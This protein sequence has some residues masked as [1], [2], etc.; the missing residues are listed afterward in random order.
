MMTS[1]WYR[2]CVFLHILSA[3]IYLG[4][5]LFIVMVLAPLLRSED[6]RP[7][8]TRVLHATGQKFKR[9]SWACFGLLIL[10]GL[11]NAIARYGYPGQSW[12]EWAGVIAGNNFL[13]HK[14]Y[15]LT[16]I[17]GLSY[18]HDFH[19]GPAAVRAMR[20]AADAPETLRLRRRA[21]W[22]GRLNLLFA[23]FILWW[24][25]RLVRG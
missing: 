16:L 22:I 9:I 24:A 2:P 4:G 17:L 19:L 25:L 10:T 23:L 1:W 7:V 11:G 5:L 13:M 3:V 18:V 15:T 8:A 21:T 14:I 6:F 12:G 20:T